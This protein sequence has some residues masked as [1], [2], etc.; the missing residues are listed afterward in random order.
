IRDEVVGP[1]VMCVGTFLPFRI[2]YWLNG[3]SFIERE[4]LREDVRFRKDDMPSW[5]SPIPKRCR[6]R[7]IA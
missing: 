1:M 4:L 5:L 2:S 6:P 3:H 7:R